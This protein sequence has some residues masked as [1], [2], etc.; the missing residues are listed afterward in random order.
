M[1]LARDVAAERFAVF[2]GNKSDSDGYGYRPTLPQEG[3]SPRMH[4][5]GRLRRLKSSLPTAKPAPAGAKV[6]C[7]Q[8]AI[9]VTRLEGG[10]PL[11]TRRTSSEW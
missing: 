9:E 11:R 3:S 2:L 10:W 1:P 6:E 7:V 4:I 5:R 8:T